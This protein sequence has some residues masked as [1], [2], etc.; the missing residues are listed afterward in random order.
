MALQL[1]G[2]YFELDAPSGTGN[3]G[4]AALR[5]PEMKQQKQTFSFVQRMMCYIVGV[6]VLLFS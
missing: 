2:F 5:K 4:T 3:V 1:A 6:Y